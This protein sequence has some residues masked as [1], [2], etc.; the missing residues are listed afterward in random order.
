MEHPSHT[1]CEP[2]S[3]PLLTAWRGW[4]H[5][6][7]VPLLPRLVGG[8]CEA[9]SGSGKELDSR[10]VRWFNYHSEHNT[11]LPDY[12]LLKFDGA[13]SKWG[14]PYFGEGVCPRCQGR[15][16]ESQMNYPNGTREIRH[17]CAVCGVDDAP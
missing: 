5:Q 14:L 11:G 17:S 4:P 3:V 10:R 6:R 7:P 9:C 8:A 15:T 13:A 1:Y 12:W 2:C 16:I